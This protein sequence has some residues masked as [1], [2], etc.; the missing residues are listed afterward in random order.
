MEPDCDVAVIGAG[1]AGSYVA[2][3]LA[4]AGRRVLLLEQRRADSGVPCCTGIVGS[5]YVTLLSLERDLVLAK[6]RSATFF[7]PGGT[8][9]RVAADAVQANVLDRGLL[10]RRLR[11]RAVAAGAELNQG[12][13]VS[14][15]SRCGQGLE[16]VCRSD[17]GLEK[18]RCRALV[19]AAGVSPGLAREVGLGLPGRFLVGAHA[20]VEMD[21]VPETEVHFMPFGLR[22]AFAWLVPVAERRVR[23]GV[24][25]A[26][27]AAAVARSFMARPDVRKRIVRAPDRIGQR[28]VP[29]AALRR[30]HVAGVLAVGDAAG[31][32]KAT[33]GGGLY[34]GAVAA[35]GA[36]EILDRALEGDNLSA[37]SLEAYEAHLRSA[38]R[39]EQRRGAFARGIYERLTPGQVDRI[40]VRAKRSGIAETLLH[41]P[42]FS[43]DRHS[44]TL[45]SGLVR[46]LPWLLPFGT[47]PTGEMSK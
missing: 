18:F 9:L 2:S 36:A 29:V 27:S 25:C 42:T 41:S 5:A 26:R 11:Q 20:E 14:S 17:G 37:C 21:G 28:P 31:Q 19:L 35:R 33:T 15:V 10:E 40:I 46:C 47:G 1:P 6:A 13:L 22:G 43:F 12:V 39:A 23:L 44:M 24:L 38:I 45:L 7:S 4:E 16:I 3:L 34:F 8:S 30:A 32:V